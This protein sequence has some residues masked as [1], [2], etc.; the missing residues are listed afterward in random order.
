MWGF[1]IWIIDF[2]IEFWEILEYLLKNRHTLN[3]KEFQRLLFAFFLF[4]NIFDI[5]FSILPVYS[6]KKN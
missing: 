1:I 6:F 3:T 5:L 4:F 2:I